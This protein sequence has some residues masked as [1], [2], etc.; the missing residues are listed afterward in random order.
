MVDPASLIKRCTS[1]LSCQ[2]CGGAPKGDDTSLGDE[3]VTSLTEGLAILRGEAAP[4][5]F[6]PPP[7]KVD[8]RAIRQ[9]L[10]L[11]QAGF[12]HRFGFGLATVRD[13]EQGRYQPDQGARSYLLA[14]DVSQRLWRELCKTPQLEAEHCAG[15]VGLG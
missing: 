15:D 11:T 4:A 14:I 9:R 2:A 3:L 8:V 1:P 6:H 10:G 13:W 5:R 12:A 7:A